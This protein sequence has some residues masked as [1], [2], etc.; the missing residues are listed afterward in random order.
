MKHLREIHNASL[1]QTK[2]EIRK[3]R[4]VLVFASALDSV[5]KISKKEALASLSNFAD[6]GTF[7]LFID[8]NLKEIQVEYPS[9]DYPASF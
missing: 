3:A 1:K 2:M 8:D 5:V 9:H 7:D 6:Y 4:T